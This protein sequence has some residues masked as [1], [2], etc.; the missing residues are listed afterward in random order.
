MRDKRTIQFFAVILFILILSI[1]IIPT[2]VQ[3]KQIRILIT[4]FKINS[5]ENYNFLQRGITQM[6]QSRLDIPNKSIP[7]LSNSNEAY[8]ADDALYGNITITGT[9]INTSAKLIDKKTGKVILSF[10]QTGKKKSDI[11]KHINL[12]ARQIKIKILHVKP[13]TEFGYEESNTEEQHKK[14]APIEE[15]S[16]T[17]RAFHEHFISMSIA[18]INGDSKNETILSTKKKVYI[19]LRSNGILKEISEFKSKKHTKIISVDAG[20]INNNK[21]AE[22]YVTCINEDT[23]RPDSFIMEWNGTK[24]KRI[25]GG[26][27]WLFR[28]IKTKTKG[29]MLLGQIP[30]TGASILSTKVSQLFWKKGKL[31]S[32]TLK[33]PKYVS[34]YS[35]TYGD[36]MNN[37][38]DMLVVLTLNGKIELFNS[39]GKRI[40]RSTKDFGGSSA[41]LE[42]KGDFYNGASNFEMSRIFLQQ[43]IFVSDFDHKGKN[44]VFVVRNHDIASSLLANTRFF[45]KTYIASM[46]WDKTGLFPDSRTETFT[47]YISDYT[48]A[49]QNND[50]K[51]ELVFSIP[52]LKAVMH[53][54]Y[55]TRIYSLSSMPVKAG[56]NAKRVMRKTYK[57]EEDFKVQRM[58]PL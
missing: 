11:L 15:S 1:G 58:N 5:P 49:D 33:L 22:I 53:Q 52:I 6:L 24:F 2:K 36:V 19:Y 40:W 50:G 45:I 41:C 23:N 17:S 55:I 39:K 57:T 42:Y 47:G 43:R 4:P 30:G 20:D 48:I 16:W 7:V 38:S 28:I 35:F 29:T 27:N 37:G 9:D 21:K 34:L 8:K 12:L 18:D 56:K 25:P 13:E 26:K 3:A 54:R 10:K 32:K 31:V 46:I 44:A 14:T 51:K